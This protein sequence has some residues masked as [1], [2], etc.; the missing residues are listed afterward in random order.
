[1]KKRENNTGKKVFI[2]L[3]LCFFFLTIEYGY[4]EHLR[5]GETIPI[6]DIVIYAENFFDIGIETFNKEN[7]NFNK[8]WI[9]IFLENEKGKEGVLA[10]MIIK[11][12]PADI[13]GVQA[14]DIINKINGVE[15]KGQDDANIVL[16]KKVVEDTGKDSIVNL[17]VVR[18]GK[19]IGLRVKLF[20]KLLGESEKDDN[21][22]A[23]ESPFYIKRPKE[24]EVNSEKSFLSFIFEKNDYRTKCIDTSQRIGEE[25]FAR[26]GYQDSNTTNMF[27]LPIINYLMT[28]PF[29]VNDTVSILYEKIINERPRNIL[30]TAISILNDNEKT[31]LD[32]QHLGDNRHAQEIFVE[33]LNSVYNC[34][35][36]RKELL[37]NLTEEEFVF[38]YNNASNI[39][40]ES[41]DTKSDTI[42]KC[43]DIANKIDITR[44]L[45]CL[46]FVVNSIPIDVLQK[47]KPKDIK[48]HP[49]DLDWQRET[50]KEDLVFSTEKRIKNKGKGFAGDILFVQETDIGLIVVGG[51]KTT[52]YYDDAAVIIDVGGDDYYFNNAGSSRPGLPI[53][54]CLDFEGNDGY[55]AKSSFSQ[56]SSTFGAGILVDFNGDDTY[57]GN[58]YCQGFGLFGIG[59]LYDTNGDDLYRAQSMCQGGAAFG[60]GLL[61]D[62]NGNDQYISRLFAQGL[63]LTKGAGLLIDKN[64]NDYYYSGGKYADFRAPE[65]S[66]QSFSQGFGMGIRPEESIVG[67]SGGVG[68]LFDENGNDAYYGDYFSQGSSYYFSLGILHDNSGHDRYFSG[69]YSQGTGI[70]STIGILKDSNGNDFYNAY[71]GVSQ[72]CGYDTSIGY[73][74]DLQGNDYYK[75]NVMSQGV[76]SEKGIGVLADFSGDD[77]YYADKKSQGYSYLSR[78]EKFLGIGILGDVGGDA[79]VFSNKVENNT[80]HFLVNAGVLL[81]KGN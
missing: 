35:R 30:K 42:M 4:S 8:G 52:Y 74:I 33:F 68:L 60:V 75:S 12:S 78:N 21:I 51:P 59:L 40:F 70:H 9:G 7:V 54:V 31:V 10:K 5:N 63:G 38:L 13:A 72:G 3:I 45:H 22:K 61:H 65:A 34:L 18:D 67:A 49:F 69:R 47:I 64:G 29:D 53:S 73:L 55:N 79:D 50:N 14:G 56:G 39:W 77:Y 24:K 20:A 37:R 27:R 57:I 58:D 62:M 26:E 32:K 48:L 15:I 11:G 19:E 71:F 6:K 17:K 81:N 25:I 36:L 1:M 66:F 23:R 28:H 80:L 43:L 41:N 76:G 16:F 46:L 2:V 44:L